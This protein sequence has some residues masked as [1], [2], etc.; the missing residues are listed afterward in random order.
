MNCCTEL[1]I[2]KEDTKLPEIDRYCEQMSLHSVYFFLGVN[3]ED[4]LRFQ[5]DNSRLHLT[6]VDEQLPEQ[7]DIS[8]MGWS[9]HSL[10]LNPIDQAKNDLKR[11]PSLRLYMMETPTR[12]PTIKIWCLLRYL[13]LLHSQMLDYLVLN[14]EKRCQVTIAIKRCHIP[15]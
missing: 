9:T 3:G 4:L 8:R 12:Y 2:F 14:M 15:Y 10:G 6:L 11:N 5:H 13:T 1:Q 7:E